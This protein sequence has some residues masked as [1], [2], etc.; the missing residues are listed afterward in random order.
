MT[1]PSKASR[2]GVRRGRSR[3][4]PSIRSYSPAVESSRQAAVSAT[5][6]LNRS[7]SRSSRTAPA[8]TNRHPKASRAARLNRQCTAMSAG[9]N[10]AA[11]AAAT[12]GQPG[13]ETAR[14][15][16]MPRAI[17]ATAGN[18]GDASPRLAGVAGSRMAFDPGQAFDVKRVGEEV[19][20]YQRGQPPAGSQP[21]AHIPA[22][23]GDLTGQIQDGV[24]A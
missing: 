13:R 17:R 11:A 5:D 20:N 16:R 23:G 3:V 19:K 2:V 18:S 7:C 14:A 4:T 10:M 9:I 15:S 12:N 8:S 6:R 1:T 21:G 24:Q 22:L